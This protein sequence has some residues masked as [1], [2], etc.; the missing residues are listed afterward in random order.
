MVVSFQIIISASGRWRN[1]TL[2][3]DVWLNLHRMTVIIVVQ[4]FKCVRVTSGLL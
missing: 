2:S 1:I 4:K 3:G